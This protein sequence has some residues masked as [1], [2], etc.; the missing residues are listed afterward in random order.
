MSA[1]MLAD[2]P[3]HL[4]QSFSNS[5]Y[6]MNIFIILSHK[7]GICLKQDLLLLSR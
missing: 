2:G 3:P 1:L 5:G 4:S 7:F 6:T